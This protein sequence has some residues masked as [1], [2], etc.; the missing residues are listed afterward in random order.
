MKIRAWKISLFMLEVILLQQL[1]TIHDDEKGYYDC[2]LKWNRNTLYYFRREI[3]R[4]IDLSYCNRNPAL[5][6]LP[7]T[8]LHQEGIFLKVCG[9]AE[10]LKIHLEQ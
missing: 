1:V 6:G 9:Q 10:A 7:L 3:A 5:K 8:K 4:E 2:I